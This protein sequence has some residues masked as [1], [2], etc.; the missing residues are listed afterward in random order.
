MSFIGGLF[1]AKTDDVPSVVSSPQL[2]QNNPFTQN[3]QSLASQYGQQAG[4]YQQQQAQINQQAQNLMNQGNQLAGYANNGAQGQTAAQQQ[5]LVQALQ[6]QAAGNG[7]SVS[8]AMLQ[9]ALQANMANTNALAASQR[10]NTNAALAN[11]MAMQ[12]N[13]QSAQQAAANAVVGKQQEQLNAQNQLGSTLSGMRSQDIQN[14]ENYNNL[15]MNYNNLANTYTN[16]GLS[17]AGM[18]LNYNNLA[19]NYQNMG[20]QAANSNM[21]SQTDANK[22]NAG[23]AQSNTESQNKL[24]GGILQSGG[25]LGV[26]ALAAAHGGRI[27]GKA[28]VKGDSS[29]N[30]TVHA[31]LSPGEIVVPRSKAGDAKKAKEFIDHLMTSEGK[32][33]DK[34]DV[35]YASVLESHRKLKERVAELEKK[36]KGKK[37]G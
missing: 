32:S 16:T 36:V 37:N 17:A 14:A 4:Q 7:P 31:M 30:D 15:G 24:T 3:Y 18:G 20:L 1:S 2:N 25:S 11:R 23:I 10:G 21:Q 33:K 26:A 35:G 27:P 9:N 5:A 29:Q 8:Q 13:A 34:K 12:Q 28:P 22:I 19:Q 6:N